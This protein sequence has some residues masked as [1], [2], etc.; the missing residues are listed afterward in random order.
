[1]PSPMPLSTESPTWSPT[2][3]P[4]INAVTN[5]ASDGVTEVVT[6]I[7][8]VATNSIADECFAAMMRTA[9]DACADADASVDATPSPTIT[10]A[11]IGKTILRWTPPQPHPTPEF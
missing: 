2:L 3:P 7:S 1:M 11:P 9:S 4:T 10:A 8:A 5:A 6:Y